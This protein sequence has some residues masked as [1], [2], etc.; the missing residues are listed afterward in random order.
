[1]KSSLTNPLHPRGHAHAL[2]CDA[3]LH[4]PHGPVS[5]RSL[6][7]LHHSHDPL[8]RL[9]GPW[10]QHA[11]FRPGMHVLLC[12]RPGLLLIHVPLL[13]LFASLRSQ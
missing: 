6:P 11:G 9:H 5:L 10:L 7:V 8:L 12:I 13:P 3:L 4:L 1:M 2:L